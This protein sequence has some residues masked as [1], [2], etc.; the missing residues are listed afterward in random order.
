MREPS[1]SAVEFRRP[2][3]AGPL[4]RGWRRL[5][6]LWEWDDYSRRSWAQE[7]EDLVIRRIFEHRRQ[8]VYVDVGAHHPKRFSNTYLFYKMGW[9]G[10]NI[11]ARPG[12]MELFRKQ[13]P[14]DTNIESG[15]HEKAGM[16]EYFVF[17]EPALNGFSKELSMARDSDDNGYRLL[18]TIQVPVAPLAE[19]LEQVRCTQEIDFLTVDVEGMDLQVLRSN[20]WTRFRPK[21]VLAEV[22]QISVERLHE[23]PLV[24]YL[25]AQ[26]YE[27]FAKTYNTVIFRQAEFGE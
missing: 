10:V 2:R 22:C 27:I 6:D 26:A 9:T 24:V 19:I 25:R 5:K 16:M 3:S 13:R 21:V 1:T 15:V 23:D 11:D 18:R 7:G 12:G 4:R 17:D 14:R 8:G 20:D